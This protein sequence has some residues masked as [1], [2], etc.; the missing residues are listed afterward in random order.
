MDS[1][2]DYPLQFE[3][4]PLKLSKTAGR[5]SHKMS[6]PKNN[7]PEVKAPKAKY[8]KT[9]GEHFKDIVITA[10]IVGII[11]FIGGMTFQGKQQDAI[12]TAVKGAQTVAP[13]EVKK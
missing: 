8:S 5:I 11:A 13:T 10:L 9:R 2:T 6:Q 1:L 3:D 12:N 4:M 7:Q